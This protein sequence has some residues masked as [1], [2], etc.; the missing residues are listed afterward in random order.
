M[1]RQMNK[2]SLGRGTNGEE[3]H[4][5]VA[6]RPYLQRGVPADLKLLTDLAVHRA[7]DLG[8]PGLETAMQMIGNEVL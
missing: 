3:I 8:E 2:E 4:R 6:K 5:R 7:V 1:K